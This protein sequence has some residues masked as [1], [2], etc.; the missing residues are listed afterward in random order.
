[1]F[2]QRECSARRFT[3]AAG[4]AAIALATL[5]AL[6]AAA[7]K[8]PAGCPPKTLKDNVVDVLHG[9]R[10]PDPYRWLE[11]QNSPG[12]RKWVAAEDRCTAGR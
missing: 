12:T 7:Q 10:V 11:A 8:L 5:A 2:N 4:R 9:V 3:S 6:P 1:M